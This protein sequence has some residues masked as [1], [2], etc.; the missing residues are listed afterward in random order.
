MHLTMKQIKKIEELKKEGKKIKLEYL[1]AKKDSELAKEQERQATKHVLDNNI[2]VCADEWGIDGQHKGNRITDPQLD[3][4]I[5]EKICLNDFLP[6][7]QKAYKDLFNID[8]PINCSYPYSFEEKY[9]KLE[10]EYFK[11]ATKFLT[12]LGHEREAEQLNSAIDGYIKKEF[13]KQL[14][15]INDSFL[16]E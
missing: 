16:N 3:Y 9:W 7:L 8:N 10:K 5:D 12:I 1:Q 4:L 15:S 13:V 2:F 11:I 6:K 14:T